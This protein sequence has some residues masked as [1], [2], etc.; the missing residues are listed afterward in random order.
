MVDTDPELLAALLGLVEPV[1]RGD[2]M[3]PLRWTTKSLRHLADELTQAGHRVGRDTVAALLHQEGFSRQG[4]SRLLEG[5]RHPDRDG[6]FRYIGELVAA[7]Q[8]AG[9]PVVS[10]DAKKKEQVGDFQPG[11][12]GMAS[13][14]RSD[15]RR[16]S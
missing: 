15:E 2:P 11:R 13:R 9:E 4:N 14:D 3:C 8:V 1:E 5:V 12:A 10:V 6:Q 16:L 7:F